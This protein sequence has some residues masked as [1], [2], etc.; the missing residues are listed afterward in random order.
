MIRY[1]RIFQSI[2]GFQKNLRTAKHP[3]RM[4]TGMRY[5]HEL[6]PLLFGKL[7]TVELHGC[8]SYHMN[9]NEG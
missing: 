7:Y 2:I 5:C 6:L 4:D 3:C 1:F 9:A 8:L